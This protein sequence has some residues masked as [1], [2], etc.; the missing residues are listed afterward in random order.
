MGDVSAKDLR[1][2][3]LIADD[4]AMFAEAL[5][6]YLEK[7]YT[8]V[9][10]VLDGRAMVEAA[11]RLKP[12][13]II[14]DVGMPLL[15]GLDAARRVREQVPSVRFIFLTMQ[16]D[17]NLA[18]AALEL[19]TIAFV[20]KHSAGPELMKAIEQVLRGRP[21]LT[22]KVRSVDWVQTKAR[23]SHFSKEMTPRQTDV[24]QMLAEGRPMKEIAGLLA[25]SEKTVEFHKHH[26][27]DVFNLKSNADV[28]LFALKRGLI[29]MNNEP[30]RCAHPA[31][32]RG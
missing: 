2:Q 6:V 32:T 16:D 26:I 23:A 12:D 7:T 21:Y 17:P 25:L 14:V 22:P 15:N 29:S 24:V 4:H 13:L 30:E 10:V 3:V 11:V 31:H 5:R 20:L 27:M 18:A 9:G 28:V 19:G 1:P 8:V